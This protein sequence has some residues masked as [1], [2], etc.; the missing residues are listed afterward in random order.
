MT[1][2]GTGIVISVP[3]S[4]SI[5]YLWLFPP[6]LAINLFDGFSVSK[7]LSVTPLKETFHTTNLSMLQYDK[8]Y[9]Q[10]L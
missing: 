10:V 2:T 4:P 5:L 1:P 8:E 9:K 7:D 3:G 6:F